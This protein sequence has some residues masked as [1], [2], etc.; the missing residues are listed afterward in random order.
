MKAIFLKEKYLGH[1]WIGLYF[2]LAALAIHFFTANG[3]GYFR[4][5]LYYLAGAEHLAFGYVDYAP[6]VAWLTGLFRAVFGDSLFAIRILPALA[7]GVEI[8][9]AVLITREL[10]G[11]KFAVFLACLC[12]LAAPGIL[13]VAGYLSMNSLEPVFL[14]GAIYLLI[15][16]VKRD[17]PRYWMGI[18]LLAG[19]GLLNKHS[20]VFFAFALA[21]G[22]LFT[23]HRRLLFSRWFLA[24]GAIAFLVFLPNII[25]EYQNDWATLELLNNV[26]ETGKNVS[27]SLLAF[28]AQQLFFLLPAAA[29]VWLAGLWHFLM[30]REGRE[31]RFLGLAYIISF[32]IMAALGGKHYYLFPIYPALFAGGAVFLEKKFESRPSGAWLKRGL[33]VLIILNAVVLAPFILPVLPVEQFLKY[34]SFLGLGVPKTEVAHVGLLPQ[35]FGD[36]FG[37]PEM[38]EAVAGAYNSLTPEEKKI[39]AIYAGNYGEAGAIDLF[40]PKYG[41]PKSISSHQNYYLWGPR[42]HSGGIVIVLQGSRVELEKSFREVKEAGVV[43]HRYAM[44]EEQ[45]TIYVC[46]SLK[47]PLKEIWPELKKW[48]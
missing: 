17:E 34:Q 48:N 42:D 19:I 36:R 27:L 23:K 18:G 5:E 2:A 12:V 3:Y 35:H 25:W 45:F 38:V 4:D 30:D 24:G 33:A 26:R 31:F 20:M 32:I 10:G 40:G 11:K 41:L 15:L 6:L 46:R 8:L 22:L 28:L 16:A 13:A 7:H 43:G 39:A 29:V 1:F 21:A 47:R 14:A 9:L 37:W 44:A